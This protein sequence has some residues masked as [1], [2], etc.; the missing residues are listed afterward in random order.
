MSASTPVVVQGRFRGIIAADVSLTRLAQALA[1]LKPTPG[2]FAVLLD[3]SG[4]VLAAPDRAWTVLLGQRPPRDPKRQLAVSLLH[5]PGSA[6][7]SLRAR[8]GGRTPGV[9]P[10][11]ARG[12]AYLLAQAPMPATGWTLLLL[13]PR[14]EVT[15]QYG[16]VA[17]AITRD[18][19]R[20]LRWTVALLLGCFL[21]G[22]VTAGRLAQ[23]GI[24]RPVA[25][26]TRA[27]RDVAGGRLDVRL[28]DGARDEFG[29]LART[30][31]VMLGSLQ[32][33]AHTLK[34]SEERYELAVRGSNDG[35]WDW[36]MDSGEVYYSGR[37]MGMLGD[38][39]EPRS[40]TVD[41]WTDRLHPDDRERILRRLAHLQANRDDLLE[42]ECRLRH[43]DGQYRWIL[44][45]A[46]VQRNASGRPVRLAGSHTDITDRVEALRVLE[47]RVAARTRD[48]EALLSVTRNLTYAEQLKDNLDRLAHSVVSATGASAVTVLLNDATGST[49]E[50][51]A[52]SVGAADCP[53]PRR[54]PPMPPAPNPLRPRDPPS[55]LTGGPEVITLPLVYGERHLGLLRASY[56]DPA[57]VDD[58]ERRLLGGLATQAAVV[59]E[60]AR[61]FAAAQNHAALEERQK[62]ARDLH[63]SVSQAL[64][65]IALGGR[66]ALRHLERAPDQAPD[67]VRY[68]L[69]LAEAGLAEMRALIFE[70]RP[71]SLEQEGLSMALTKLASALHARHALEVSLDVCGEPGVPLDSKVAL[72][73]IAQEATHNTVKHARARTVQLTLT[74]GPDTVVLDIQDDGAGFDVNDTGHG[75]LG[76]TSMRERA[77]GI[78]GTCTVTSEAG[79][80]TRVRVEAPVHCP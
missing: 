75:G 65:G 74:C 59:V 32:A 31:N 4:R 30:F 68:M 76:Q 23:T 63:D 79:R 8:L 21:M 51:H 3:R 49:A 61:L 7:R 33:H 6:L 5:A 53:G 62:L 43:Q 39:A 19:D 2:G 17:Q 52:L 24:I 11:T 69:S 29:L 66:T 28:P 12:A 15:A 64:Y 20:T 70:L 80:G 38:P 46:A 55:T 1:S 42:F 72:L 41:T 13:A 26:L 57:R 10:L 34:R 71:E 48:L 18:A 60:N 14:D 77:R 37:W 73:R 40:G 27:A 45:R 58:N 9:Q 35:L 25:R 56:A 54:G 50:G 16:S 67:A 47:D 22:L 44:S 78:G 36:H